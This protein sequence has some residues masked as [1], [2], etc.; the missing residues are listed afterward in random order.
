MRVRCSTHHQMHLADRRLKPCLLPLAI[1]L[2]VSACGRS[3]APEP[4]VLRVHTQPGGADLFVNGKHHGQTPEDEKQTLLVQLSP[5]RHLIE[6][7]KAV[8]PFREWHGQTELTIA[9]EQILSPLSLRL[10]GRLTEEGKQAE[11]TLKQRQ[12]EREQHF[13]ARFALAN[14]GTATDTEARLQWMRC[15]V[16]QTWDGSTCTG[17]VETFTWTTAQTVPENFEFAGHRDWRMPSHDEL[18]GLTYCSSGHRFAPDPAG[19]GGGCAGEFRRPAI[20]RDIFPETPPRHFWTRSPHPQ[21]NY[22]AIGVSFHHGMLGAA[23]RSDHGPIR[24]VRDV[25]SAP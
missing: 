22:A 7:R 10:E 2:A 8:D 15:S 20:L 6:A 13:G 17:D 5:G 16:G 19:L 11:E 21:Y 14:D 9:A 23:S 25:K 1:A 3:D 4:G 24:L 12:A 18:H